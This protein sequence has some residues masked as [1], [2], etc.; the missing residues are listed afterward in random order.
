[1]SRGGEVFAVELGVGGTQALTSIVTDVNMTD[2][3]KKELLMILFGMGQ[4]EVNRIFDN[5]TN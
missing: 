1:M 5:D 3:Q 4:D 2:T